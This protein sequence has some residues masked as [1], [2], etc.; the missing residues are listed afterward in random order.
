MTDRQYIELAQR[1]LSKQEDK[2]GHFVIGLATEAAE[3]LDAYKKHRYY[4]RELDTVN[5][6]EEIG[7]MMWYLLQLCDELGY[8]I[9][10]AK[11]DNIAKLSKRYPD[12]F[13]DVVVRDTHLELDHIGQT[14]LDFTD[15]CEYCSGFQSLNY[16]ACGHCGKELQ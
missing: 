13:K 4:D 10:Q 16:K 5:M 15:S 6:K 1:T 12:G 9:E 2:L 8:S 3:L 11:V 7:D 14:Y